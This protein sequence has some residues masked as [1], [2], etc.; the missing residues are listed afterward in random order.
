M[1]IKKNEIEI[2][3]KNAK[4]IYTFIN[5]YIFFFTVSSVQLQVPNWTSPILFVLVLVLEFEFVLILDLNKQ[6][7]KTKKNKMKIKKLKK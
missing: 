4:N 6:T 2:K 5:I 1:N 3:K 7:K